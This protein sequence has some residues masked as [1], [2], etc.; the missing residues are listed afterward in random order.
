MR[1]ARRL[2]LRALRRA[3]R[4]TRAALAGAALTS[5]TLL[6]TAAPAPGA[7]GPGAPCRAVA[8]QVEMTVGLD[9]MK[10]RS[11]EIFYPRNE[12][13]EATL[14]SRGSALRPVET[15]GPNGCRSAYRGGGIVAVVKACGD[16]TPFRVRAYRTKRT[17]VSLVVTYRASP[18]LGG[19]PPA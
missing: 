7:A 17:R 13:L 8:C 9:Q 6:A 16:A 4:A 12:D 1:F 14:S 2:R 5:L 19:D 15:W 11:I 10:W 3:T 18:S